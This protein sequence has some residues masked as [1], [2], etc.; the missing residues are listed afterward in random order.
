MIRGLELLTSLGHPLVVGVSRKA[1]IGHLSGVNEAAA[2]MS[3]S[4]AA[5]L[6]ALSQGA[7][8]LRVH[9]VAETM[10]AIR[11]WQALIPRA[12]AG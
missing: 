9:D 10:G 3:G 12:E 1:F 2:R 7:T 11:V 8:V 6:C 5:G 4:I